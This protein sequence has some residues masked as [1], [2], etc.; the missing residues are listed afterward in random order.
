MK[1]ILKI[2]I[3]PGY[4]A[5]KIVIQGDTFT[6]SSKILDV[7]EEIFGVDRR[8]EGS[9]YIRLEEQVGERIK[10]YE[11]LIGDVTELSMRSMALVEENSKILEKLQTSSKFVAP[12]FKISIQGALSLALY[13]KEKKDAESKKNR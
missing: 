4:D 8:P 2:S 3:D 6:F 7:T 5:Y 9:Y 10:D 1:P 13:T 12:I 11:Y